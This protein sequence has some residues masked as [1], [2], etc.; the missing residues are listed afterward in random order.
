[1]KNAVFWNVAPC[2][3]CVNR[4][5][6]GTYRLNFQAGK[7]VQS[8]ATCLRSFLARGFFYPEDG[9]DIFL[10]NVGLHKIYAA[11]HPR[12][13]QS[14]SLFIGLAICIVRIIIDLQTACQEN[15]K[16]CVS[17]EN[18]DFLHVFFANFYYIVILTFIYF[19]SVFSVFCSF[20]VEIFF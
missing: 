3:S 2:R 1:M 20:F 12:R 9:G 11:P 5:F 16:I 6:G 8:A 4:C 14:V 19:R 18:T 15:I 17:V 13:R 10:R 7:R